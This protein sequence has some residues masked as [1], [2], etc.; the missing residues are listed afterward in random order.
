[1]TPKAARSRASFSIMGTLL[2]HVGNGNFHIDLSGGSAA[3]RRR[4]SVTRPSGSPDRA[5]ER[6]LAF[7]RD[8]YGPARNRDRQAP[9]P[10]AAEHGEERGGHAVDQAER[11]IRGRA[12]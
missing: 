9:S 3:Q 4:P 1:M 11:S 8:L 7:G 2:G 10:R 12:S 5:V 6:A